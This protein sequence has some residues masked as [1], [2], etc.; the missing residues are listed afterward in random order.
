M[1]ILYITYDGVLDPLG[2]SQVL[3]YL[4]RLTSQH[5][6]FL[7]S[8]E[9]A[10]EW[11][12]TARRHSITQKI[13][14]AKINW[15][16]LT[17][18]KHPSVLATSFDLLTGFCTASWL[19]IH[20]SVSVVHARSL[21][22]AIICLG[23]KKLFRVRF[24]YDIRGFWVDCRRE[25][26]HLRDSSF[27]YKL[28]KNFEERCLRDADIVVSL[29]EKAVDA[30]KAFPFLADNPPRF[31]VITT[32][33]DL[34]L[35]KPEPKSTVKN[36]QKPFTLGYVGS[37]GKLYMFDE[38]L[39]CFTVLCELI[40][41]ARLRIINRNDHDYIQSKISSHGIAKDKVDLHATDFAQVPEQLRMMDAGTCFVLP[42]PSMIAAAPTKIGEYLACGIPCIANSHS[43]DVEK[44]L[45]E[46]QVGV[47]VS[48]FSRQAF[49]DALPKLLALVDNPGTRN[50]CIGV[51]DREF[52]LARG[53]E[54]YDRIYKEFDT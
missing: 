10:Q 21:I 15:T 43:G 4:T 13:Q 6:I 5:E 53:V 3:A 35:F 30:M 27:V 33:T 8:Y 46:N 7:L 44:I 40:P 37:V 16:S 50:R 36:Q 32:C 54:S 31:E 11:R 41:E 20:N 42:H 17:Y 22:P 51:A 14:S 24:I 45:N 9:K 18:H 25:Q 29:T 26:G 34:D 49:Q 23:L 2:Q 38:L 12:K 19:V 52:S 1:A 28:L 39:E 47:C 48:D